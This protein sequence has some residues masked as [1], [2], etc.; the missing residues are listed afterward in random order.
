MTSI[1]DTK[2]GDEDKLPAV[3]DQS[4]AARDLYG[5]QTGTEGAGFDLA[6]SQGRLVLLRFI[7]LL[8]K[9]KVLIAGTCLL[10][11]GGGFVRTYTTTPLYEASTTIQIDEQAPK[12]FN[13][14][15]GVSEMVT[16]EP[17]FFETQYQLLKSRSL[18]QRVA[19]SLDAATISSMTKRE[20]PSIWDRL[21]RIL[22]GSGAETAERQPLTAASLAAAQD[23][24]TGQIMGGLSIQPVPMS[25]IVRIGFSS[26][27]PAL[28]QKISIAV[29]E[30]FV[31]STLDRRSSASAYASQFIQDRLQQ[32]KIKLEESEKQ[33]VAY[34]RKEGLVNID[35]KQPETTSRLAALNA[36]LSAATAERIKN[37]QLWRQA[38]SSDGLGLPQVLSDHSVQAAREKRAQLMADYRDK[39]N[40]LKPAFPEMVQLHAQISE[41]DRQIKAQVDLVKEA[42]KDQFEASKQQ[43]ESLAQAVAGLRDQTLQLR[44]VGIE[45][46]ILQR[47]LDT[48]KTLY[49][50][51]LQQYKE[52]GVT[53]SIGTN[54]VS[55]VDRAE[56]P[57][58]PY[59]PRLFTNLLIALVTGAAFSSLLVYIFEILDDTFKGPEAVEDGLALT[60]LGVIPLLGQNTDLIGE[61][62]QTPNSAVAEAYRSLRTALQFSTA[63]GAPRV[64][65]V[66]SAKPGE[67]K[68]T[69][70]IS[71]AFNFAQ[72]G[73][74]VLLIDAD[75][76]N[77]SLGRYLALDNSLGLS[78]YLASG[79]DIG[80]IAQ[81]CALTNVSVITAGPLPP[82]PAELL[83]GTKLPDLLARASETFDV[84]VIDGP[85]VMGL[86]DAPILSSITAGTLLVIQAG[87]TRRGLVKAAVKRL[88][89]ARARIVGAVLTKFDADKS[90][91]TYDYSYSYSYANAKAV[92]GDGKKPKLAKPLER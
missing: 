90:G 73:M 26:P 48:N 70:S 28:A 88:R 34:A 91:F 46:N 87:S 23:A 33:V 83:A 35:E 72:I 66:T 86:A 53:A 75:L 30:N 78:N 42:I 3:P 21:R 92:P 25:R 56:M 59:S 82:N 4:L 84:V 8:F 13:K 5:Y 20:A 2:L 11:M 29:A 52:L 61:I 44:S 77:P 85:P 37:E 36:S 39:L 45:Y 7:D 40:V 60:A 65:L 27:S 67:G 6:Q 79:A 17:F 32:L 71:L 69:T 68:S 43:E 19:K 24:A 12:V 51:L 15:T 55:I 62:R 14:A 41:L 38:E 81:T 80:A 74:R 16:R 22:P 31:A 10:A 9:Y 54:N 76:R 64:L 89:F 58:A 57:G 1:V 50:G 63:S 18:A 49:D 47:E